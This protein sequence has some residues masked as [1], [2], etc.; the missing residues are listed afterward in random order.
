MA[1]FQVAFVTDGGSRSSYLSFMITEASQILSAYFEGRKTFV[2]FEKLS[3]YWRPTFVL[4]NFTPYYGDKISIKKH[5]NPTYTRSAKEYS[6]VGINLMIF[7]IVYVKLM[8]YKLLH[9]LYYISQ[10]FVFVFCI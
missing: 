10:A 3:I 8:V 7:S 1:G 5:K 2:Y 9:M 6:D 4:S